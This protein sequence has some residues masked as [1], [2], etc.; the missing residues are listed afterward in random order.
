[1]IQ[2]SLIG[3]KVVNLGFESVELFGAVESTAL[4]IF[5][6]LDEVISGLR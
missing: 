3:V 4:V 1:M 5:K 6:A 2:Q